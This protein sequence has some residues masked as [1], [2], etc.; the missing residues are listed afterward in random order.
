MNEHVVRN[1]SERTGHR[2]QWRFL[3]DVVSS[4]HGATSKG[5]TPKFVL[6]HGGDSGGGA[7]TSVATGQ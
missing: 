6:T 4:E 7:I 2:K 5:N 1:V 3:H